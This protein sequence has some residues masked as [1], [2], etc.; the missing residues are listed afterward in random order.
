MA[1]LQYVI[2][3]IF[4]VLLS[5]GLCS[6]ETEETEGDGEG[7]V[8]GMK[9]VP[10]SEQGSCEPEAHDRRVEATDRSNSCHCS[11]RS[12]VMSSCSPTSKRISCDL[13]C[14]AADLYG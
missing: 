7:D 10:L 14:L 2:L 12:S 13:S 8:D 4:R 1:K 9:M 6:D 3:R 5:N 11:E